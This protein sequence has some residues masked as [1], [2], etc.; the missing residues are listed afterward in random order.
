MEQSQ[1]E[2]QLEAVKSNGSNGKLRAGSDGT[3]TPPQVHTLVSQ[4]DGEL[5]RPK[6]SGND[7]Y[8][9]AREIRRDPTIKMVR[10]LAMAPILVGEWEYET[11]PNAP[12]GATE[13]VRDVMDGLR[14]TLLKSSMC[15]MIDYGWQPYEVIH[16]AAPDG[17]SRPRLKPLLQ[18]ITTILVD[19]A[20]G[21]FFGLRQDPNSS[22]DLSFI[23][24]LEDECFVIS[25]DVE[26][27]DWYGEAT[28]RA[29]ERV[30]DEG[31]TIG[32]NSRKYDAKIAGTHWVIYYPL[33]VSNYGG[34]D[35]DN[36]EIARK[37]LQQ[38]ESVG[39]I[40]VPRSVIQ[41]VDAMNAAAAE[42]EA[43]QWLIELLSDEGKG[44]TQFTD[45]LKYLDVLK[46]RAFGFPERAILEGQFGTKA[47]AEAHGDVAVSNLEVRHALLCQA[48]NAKLVDK[49]LEWN[50]GPGYEGTVKI[51]PAP[52]QDAKKA[53]FARIY[54]I[55][56]ANP[57][58]FMTEYATLDLQQIRERLGL[59]E[60]P[61][62]PA[63]QDEY[64]MPTDGDPAML[65]GQDAGALPSLEF[66]L[67]FDES[68]HPRAQAGSSAGG[69]FTK[70]GGIEV[71]KNEH[72]RDVHSVYWRGR[73]IGKV[74][75]TGDR[76]VSDDGAG[77]SKVHKR[78]EDAVRHLAE[79]HVPQDTVV[80]WKMSLRD[81]VD[82]AADE[83]VKPTKA[84][85]KN[86]N[87]KKGVA[88]IHGM[89]VAVETPRGERR[90][91]G[92]P[93]LPCHYGYVK[94]TR[95]R[96]DDQVDVFVGKHPEVE[97]V[98]VIDQLDRRGQFDEHKAMLGFK[99]RE[100]AV[101]AYRKSYDDGRKVGP[102]T[103]MTVEQFK[104]WLD[105]GDS[106]QPASEQNVAMSSNLQSNS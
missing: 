11:L 67:A 17:S 88:T 51:Q 21:S 79:P 13:L 37:L 22:L 44:A 82:E 27:T 80:S 1:R 33:G 14:L 103:T 7:F 34:Q 59:P 102:V 10:E 23:Y 104:R 106:N 95:G 68:Q 87:Y 38:A 58:G 9:K 60:L 74:L 47:E 61:T 26:G 89:R 32:K 35:L 70:K 93:K 99:S 90:K 96:D 65:T 73:K 18:D 12:P 3:R 100:K 55:L 63:G 29:L 31:E 40:C 15:G 2:I 98:H 78:Y 85:A 83:T 84:Q 41:A 56:F 101:K 94:G 49:V 48:Y 36:G 16:D 50:F 77:K 46:V 57:Q 81:D 105:E 64:G 75:K 53:M 43:T 30:Y 5:A 42:K 20:D 6:G 25:Q 86:G 72:T 76:Y 4:T 19:A 52:I 97:F 8:R 45:K 54:E 66:S 71:K 69:E 62:M 24:M 28:L 92:W 91:P 39:G